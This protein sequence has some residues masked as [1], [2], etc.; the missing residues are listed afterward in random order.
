MIQHMKSGISALSLTVLT[1]LVAGC[2][3]ENTMSRNE[4]PTPVSVSDITYGTVSSIF[5]TNSTAVS[6]SEAQLTTEMAGK[7]ILW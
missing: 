5:T 4:I 1:L 3:H 7:Y 6:G 2:K